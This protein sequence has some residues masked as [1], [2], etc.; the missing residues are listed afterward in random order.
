MRWI[1]PRE[2]APAANLLSDPDVHKQQAKNDVDR[3]QRPHSCRD[4]YSHYTWLYFYFRT[5]SVWQG[6][7]G[8]RSRQLMFSGNDDGR[9][10]PR[11]APGWPRLGEDTVKS[12]LADLLQYCAKTTHAN[13]DRIQTRA[14]T[15]TELI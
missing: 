9:R 7:G 14:S 8:Q 12:F 11:A 1:L 10:L 3:S 6:G 13:E 5:G 15:L 4:Y 2:G